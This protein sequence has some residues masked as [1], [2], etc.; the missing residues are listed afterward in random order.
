MMGAKVLPLSLP[1]RLTEWTSKGTAQSHGL[2]ATER[3]ASTPWGR[4][5]RLVAYVAHSGASR[6][7]RTVFVGSGGRGAVTRRDMPGESLLP[8]GEESFPS[9][10]E[11]CLLGAW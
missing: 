6:G 2:A 11:A 7:R 9:F 10:S 4:G 8:Q 3:G 5:T 1:S